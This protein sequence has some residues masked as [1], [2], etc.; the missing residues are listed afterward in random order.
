MKESTRSAAMQKMDRF[1]VQIGFQDDWPDYAEFWDLAG[2]TY[3]DCVN[4]AC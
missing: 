2:R 1:C 3:V 4:I